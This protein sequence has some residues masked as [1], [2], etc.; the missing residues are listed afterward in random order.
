MHFIC[1]SDNMGVSGCV[2]VV[3]LRCLWLFH[4]HVV[5]YGL[6]NI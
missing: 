1:K 6:N 3:C 2:S 4:V 5:Y